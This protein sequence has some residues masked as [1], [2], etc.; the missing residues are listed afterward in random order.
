MM[1]VCELHLKDKRCPFSL[2]SCSVSICPPSV[3]IF[4]DL[5][6]T[7]RVHLIPNQAESLGDA[8]MEVNEGFT[9]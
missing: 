5:K 2:T 3:V 8:S 4:L 9:E 6:A 1:V 7:V